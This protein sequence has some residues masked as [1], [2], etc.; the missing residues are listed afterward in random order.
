MFLYGNGHDLDHD[1]G[2][3]WM[4]LAAAHGNESAQAYMVVLADSKHAAQED[5][6]MLADYNNRL[7]AGGSVSAQRL[8]AELY[9]SGRFVPRNPTEAKRWFVLAARQ[10]D[11]QSATRLKSFE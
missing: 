9:D 8:I 3:R 5:R 2:T 6:K 11:A 7:G 1:I 4:A 10:G